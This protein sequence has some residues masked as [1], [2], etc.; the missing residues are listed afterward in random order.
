[1][2]PP[3]DLARV[4]DR[5]AQAGRAPDVPEFRAAAAVSCKRAAS[6]SV[7]GHVTRGADNVIGSYETFS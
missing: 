2:R 5:P 3:A 7:P 6:A 1:M 4:V